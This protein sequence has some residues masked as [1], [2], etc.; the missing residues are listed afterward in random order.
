VKLSKNSVFHDKLRHIKIKYHY[1]HEMVHKRE[2]ILNLILTDKQK[3]DI[4][5]KALSRKKFRYFR[6]KLGLAEVTI[7]SPKI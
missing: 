1:I 3:I 5:T 6:D 4:L 2:V 7:L